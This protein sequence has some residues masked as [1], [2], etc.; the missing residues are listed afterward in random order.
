MGRYGEF[1]DPFGGGDPAPSELQKA[2]GSLTRAET[3][4]LAKLLYKLET[5]FDSLDKSALYA[6]QKEV[7]TLAGRFQRDL[8]RALD[9]YAL[10]KAQQKE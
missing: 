8:S 5:Q 6:L 4:R 1:G 2:A 10:R 7:G 9:I 3:K